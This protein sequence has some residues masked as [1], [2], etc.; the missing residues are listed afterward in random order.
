MACVNGV[1]IL[2]P[3]PIGFNFMSNMIAYDKALMYSLIC[4]QSS[5]VVVW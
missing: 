3:I 1:N 2:I 4:R 5:S